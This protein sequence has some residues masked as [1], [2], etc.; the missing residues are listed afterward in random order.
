MKENRPWIEYIIQP[1]QE[2]MALQEILTGQMKISRR[3]IQKLTRTKGILYNG[4]PTFLKRP[5]KAGHVVQVAAEVSNRQTLLPQPI[6]FGILYEDQEILVI[7]KPA[8]I[9]VHPIHSGQTDTLANG[10]AWHMRE[11]GLAAPVRLVHRLDRDT[12]GILIVGKSAFAH[13]HLD[14]QLRERKLM[15]RYLA[16]V[17]GEVEEEQGTLAYPIGRDPENPVKRKV[18]QDGEPAVTHFWLRE[19]WKGASLLE[20]SLETG[21]THQIRVHLAHHG[22][23]VLGDRQYG[24]PSL[25]IKRQALHAFRLSFTH[26]RTGAPLELEAPLAEDMAAAI[27]QLKQQNG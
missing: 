10:I 2:G 25:L 7:N 16:L 17:E 3:M 6:P 20:L 15:R 9:N 8:G 11:Q 24:H 1:E 23:P 14:R 12:S 18:R 13:Q 27:E 21:R 26:P 5:V 19:K 22:Y 4:K